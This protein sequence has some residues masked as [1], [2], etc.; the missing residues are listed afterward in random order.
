M[1]WAGQAAEAW[2]ARDTSVQCCPS[3]AAH[4]LP[5]CSACSTNGCI[6]HRTLPT[7]VPP[8]ALQTRDPSWAPE[9]LS[10]SV[11]VRLRMGLVTRLLYALRPGVL[12]MALLAAAAVAAVL[13]G[14]TAAVV[15]LALWAYTIWGGA[16]GAEQDGTA[17]A[18][19]SEAEELS[20]T[21][22]GADE[23]GS[24]SGLSEVESGER[25]AARGRGGRAASACAAA[26]FPSKQV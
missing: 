25:L 17:R 11:H 10:A 13:G 14:S 3:H 1:V 8:H 15:F 5:R 24:I 16:A 20:S 6:F 22:S 9:V 23:S 26:V 21:L 2:G 18:A 7:Y 4:V 19:G 12:P